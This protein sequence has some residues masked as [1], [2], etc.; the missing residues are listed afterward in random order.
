MKTFIS[1]KQNFSKLNQP[2]EILYQE[3]PV[4]NFI[5]P[6]CE[7]IFLRKENLNESA[8]QIFFQESGKNLLLTNGIVL[9]IS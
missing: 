9:E 5:G 6:L 7:E 4:S 8:L 2:V 1:K 3:L